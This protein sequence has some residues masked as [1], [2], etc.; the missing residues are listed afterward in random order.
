MKPLNYESSQ[1]YMRDGFV[2]ARDANL[3]IASSPMLYGLAIYTVLSVNWLESEQKL[4]V[5]RLRDH[6]R[7]LCQSA[8]I[9]GMADFATTYPLER[10]TELVRE[11]LARNQVRED[12][13][14]R[15]TI[16]IDELIAGTRIDGLKN[17]F[18]MYVYPMGQILPADGIHACVSSWTRVA[19]NMVPARAKVNGG[20][21][22]ASLMKNEALLNGYDEAI[23]LDDTGH[24][25]ES[26]V[27]NLFIVR[28]GK[29]ITPDTSTDILEGIT[30]NSVD[31]LA[32][33]L[34]IPF[35]ERP[36][37]RT[38]L[39][40]ADEMFICGSSARIIPVLS[41]DRRPVGNGENGV[42]TK[43]LATEYAKV[44]RGQNPDFADWLTEI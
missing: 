1:V 10:F 18:C 29:L 23:S 15:A 32:N 6:W 44:Q 19:D 20:Y 42:I 43:Q 17:S 25:A 24:V 4:S 28:D 38:E 41:V 27:A 12:A 21:V 5:F 9:M 39:Y 30:R 35:L 37:D 40:V 13:L 3:N 31:R 16:F 2:P 34:G 11:L 33:Y 26:T 14:V 22:N 36:V 7:R 8:R